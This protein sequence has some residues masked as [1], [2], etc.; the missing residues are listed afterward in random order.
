MASKWE[1]GRERRKCAKS[2]LRNRPENF[3]RLFSFKEFS[4]KMEVPI[5]WPH[6]WLKTIV[7]KGRM[8]NTFLVPHFPSQSTFIFHFPRDKPPLPSLT[9][10]YFFSR[11][12]VPHPFGHLPTLTWPEAGKSRRC[13]EERWS[14]GIDS[15]NG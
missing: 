10:A 1:W 12:N 11:Q 5:L 14:G 7:W 8:T 9:A 15:G 6:R 3:G 13:P 4:K 2:Q